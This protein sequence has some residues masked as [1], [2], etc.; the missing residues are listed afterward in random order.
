[1][2]NFAFNFVDSLIH[3]GNNNVEV[4]NTGAKVSF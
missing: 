3:A 4:Y 2:K 1:M